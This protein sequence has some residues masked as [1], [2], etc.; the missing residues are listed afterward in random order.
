MKKSKKQLKHES[1]VEKSRKERRNKNERPTTYFLDMVILKYLKKE[2]ITNY[3]DDIECCVNYDGVITAEITYLYSDSED[4]WGW[5]GP[6]RR[7]PDPETYTVQ[8]TE[9]WEYIKLSTGAMKILYRQNYD[10]M[11]QLWDFE[12]DM[13]EWYLSVLKDS[14][15]DKFMK[16]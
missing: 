13:D 5:S 16:S 8:Y 1:R 4:S 7:A 3:Y 6:S 15:M 2:K 14:D 11:S 12:T 9:V 10:V